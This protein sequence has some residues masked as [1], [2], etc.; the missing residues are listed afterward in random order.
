M[1]ARLLISSGRKGAKAKYQTKI[2]IIVSEP[3]TRLVIY[4]STIAL[5]RFYCGYL[6]HLLLSYVLECVLRILC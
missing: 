4:Q 1:Q 2:S 5:Q 3:A 6:Y